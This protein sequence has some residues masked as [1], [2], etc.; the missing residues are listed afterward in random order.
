MFA[1][2]Q[3]Q[4][5][6]VNDLT[7]YKKFTIFEVFLKIYVFSRNK[8]AWASQCDGKSESIEMDG[9]SI[10]WDWFTIGK[11]KNYTRCFL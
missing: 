9:F 6:L 4:D 10:S 3:C 8:N 7:F 1:K 2:L 11:I 5:V